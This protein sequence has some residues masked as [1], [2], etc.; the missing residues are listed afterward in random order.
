MAFFVRASLDP[1]GD[2]ERGFSAIGGHVFGTTP[3]AAAREHAEFE[4][5]YEFLYEL[6]ED[7]LDDEAILDYLLENGLQYH[8]ELEGWVLAHDGLCAYAAFDS[9]EDALEAVATDDISYGGDLG[10][11]L[12]APIYVF[13]GEDGP[14]TLDDGVLFYPSGQFWLA[15]P[16][17][18]NDE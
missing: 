8:P 6:E 7:E 10:L 14:P 15:R 2:I 18:A 13:E 5:N 17:P 16:A 3:R 12:M 9:L 1:T 4:G 11:S